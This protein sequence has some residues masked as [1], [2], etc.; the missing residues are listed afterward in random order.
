MYSKSVLGRCCKGRV[1]FV[2]L[3]CRQQPEYIPAT[4]LGQVHRWCSVLLAQLFRG[5]VDLGRPADISLYHLGCCKLA[6]PDGRSVYLAKVVLYSL[7]QQ[8]QQQQYSLDEVLE[9]FRQAGAV[10]QISAPKCKQ[11]QRKRSKNGNQCIDW[12]PLRKH[13]LPPQLGLLCPRAP[14]LSAWLRRGGPK[15]L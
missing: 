9:A 1:T 10:L 15:V 3:L 4:T 7:Q 2:F 12:L 8:H 6:L 13:L 11:C 5:T 14:W